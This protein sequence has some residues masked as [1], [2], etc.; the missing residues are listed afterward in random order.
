MSAGFPEK[1]SKN[2]FPTARK[3]IVDKPGGSHYNNYALK[4]AY[5]EVLE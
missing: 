3:N 2:P 5:A 1:S 4:Y